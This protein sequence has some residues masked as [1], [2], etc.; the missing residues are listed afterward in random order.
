M[1][2]KNQKRRSKNIKKRIDLLQLILKLDFKTSS[3]ILKDI[4]HENQEY[5]VLRR[6]FINF[7][8]FL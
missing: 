5:L 4:V 3:E 7:R 1:I 6:N 8:D 2:K